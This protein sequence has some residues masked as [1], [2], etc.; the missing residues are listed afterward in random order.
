[1]LESPRT[2]TG[3]RPLKVQSCSFRLGLL[4]WY[5][6]LNL[7]GRVGVR[8]RWRG[9]ESSGSSEVLCCV[10]AGGLESGP[11]RPGAEPSAL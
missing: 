2:R 5:V 7:P 6:G 4:R 8:V 9:G 11:A 3:F 1:M 10:P